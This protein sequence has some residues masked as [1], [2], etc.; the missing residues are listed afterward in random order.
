M[1][2]NVNCD[3]IGCRSKVSIEWETPGWICRLDELEVGGDGGY[4]FCPDCAQ[5]A[6]W[7]G[8]QCPGCVQAPQD[9]ALF[10]QVLG[11]RG[12][13]LSA[14]ETASICAG[15]CP[16]RTN[17]TSEYTAASGFRSIDLYE[18][19]PEGTGQFIVSAISSYRASDP[20]Y[21]GTK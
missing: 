13:S 16:F 21:F 1:K 5:Q 11:Y 14:A 9:C 3:G 20:G 2:V 18:P 7:F 10:E 17:G 8:S 4:V 6:E 15:R 12:R 19:A